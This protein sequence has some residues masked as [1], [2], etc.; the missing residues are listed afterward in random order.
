MLLDE[1][2]RLLKIGFDFVLFLPLEELRAGRHESLHHAHAVRPRAAARLR[3]LLFGLRAIFAL[4]R[5]QMEVEVTATL[6][7]VWIAGVILFCA[8]IVRLNVGNLRSFVLGKAENRK[9]RLTHLFLPPFLPDQFITQRVG[10]LD[11]LFIAD[12][13]PLQLGGQIGNAVRPAIFI[14]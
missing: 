5:H 7:N 2:Q 1:V 3:N 14:M 10:K 12:A 13:L 6:I 4:R 8:L 9:L 11:D